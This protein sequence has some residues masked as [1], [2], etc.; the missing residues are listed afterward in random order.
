M[1]TAPKAPS[2]LRLRS[3]EGVFLKWWRQDSNLG[4]LS[5]QIY[6]GLVAAKPSVTFSTSQ[7]LVP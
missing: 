5:Q 4:R 3:S 2:T 7:F 1:I 6:S